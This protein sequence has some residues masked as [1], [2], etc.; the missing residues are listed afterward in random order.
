MM[1]AHYS[2]CITA[3]SRAES[4]FPTEFQHCNISKCLFYRKFQNWVILSIKYSVGVALARLICAFCASILK[5]HYIDHV[6]IRRTTRY[7]C[8]S[9]SNFSKKKLLNLK[10]KVLCGILFNLFSYIFGFKI[11]HPKL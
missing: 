9:T 3:F 11:L 8:F 6:Y 7:S 2:H 5:I 10:L 1:L 4:F